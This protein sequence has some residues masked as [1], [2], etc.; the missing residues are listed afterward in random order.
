[1]TGVGLLLLAILAHEKAK[2]LAWMAREEE[3][4][5]KEVARRLEAI[6]KMEAD[7]KSRTPGQGRR[8]A[9]T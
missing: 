5:V 6:T 2:V 3:H 4:R 1:M 9:G 7:L 8:G